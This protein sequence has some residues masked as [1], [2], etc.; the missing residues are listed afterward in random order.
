M[1]VRVRVRMAMILFVVV[2]MVMMIMVIMMVVLM[3]VIMIGQMNVEFDSGNPRFFAARNVEVI[4]IDVEFL[5]F[6]L[7][8]V[9][10]DAEIQQR[11]DEHIAAD[12][13]ENIQVK[14]FHTF[15]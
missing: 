10:I 2:V 9:R 4:T 7:E 8:L 12:S 5:Q 3:A 15:M 11:A 13:A 6:V 1:L 14:C